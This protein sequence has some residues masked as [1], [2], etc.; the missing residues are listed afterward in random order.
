MMMWAGMLF[1]GIPTAAVLLEKIV[2]VV[3]GEVLT[4]QDFEDLLALRGVWQPS[5]AVTGRQQSFQRFV[6][7]TLIWQEAVRTRMV[8]VAEAQV[9]QSLHAIAAQRER[10]AHLDQVIRDR[11]LTMRQVR[12][13]V[14][15]QLV[16]DAFIERR[17]RL[18]V[19]VS[20][21]Q[22]TQYYHQHQQAIG[23]PLSDEVHEQ[24]RRILV[25]Q[26]TLSSPIPEKFGKGGRPR[27]Q[28]NAEC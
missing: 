24:I 22:I 6:D 9:T 11:G 7:D 20:D 2:A 19:R 13:W 27:S 4:L 5:A 3:D 12:S 8:E 17:I 14:R 1:S 15:Q 10:Q 28:T 25:V 21:R 18:F 26:P 16:V 23:E